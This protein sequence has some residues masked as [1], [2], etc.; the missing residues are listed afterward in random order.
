LGTNLNEIKMKYNEK[1][2]KLT[3]KTYYPYFIA[4]F[5]GISPHVN[6]IVYRQGVSDGDVPL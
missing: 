2:F 5:C 1:C 4:P 6:V 3:G